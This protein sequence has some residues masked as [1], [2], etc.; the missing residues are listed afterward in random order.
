MPDAQI[1]TRIKEKRR[2]VPKPL[3]KPPISDRGLTRKEAAVTV[4][5]SE[6]TLAN[7]GT[8]GHGPPFRKYRGHCIYLESEL[9]AWIKS[10]PTRGGSNAAA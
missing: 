5:Y 7:L 10:I 4:G 6:K 8:L 3:A 1:Q 2:R 9:L